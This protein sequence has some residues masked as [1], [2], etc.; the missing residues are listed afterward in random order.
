MW[1]HRS[2][3]PE[4]YHAQNQGIQQ[5]RKDKIRHNE[6]DSHLHFLFLFVRE[7]TCLRYADFMVVFCTITVQGEKCFKPQGRG[8]SPT[9]NGSCRLS[10]LRTQ[11]PHS[12]I[13]L[14][15][16]LPFMGRKPLVYKK[17]KQNMAMAEYGKSWHLM[18]NLR[19]WKFRFSIQ[20]SLI[21]WTS[22]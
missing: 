11:M 18:M 5:S 10:V 14:S 3:V 4:A 2:H 8:G 20:K 21:M 15:W 7:H 17:E 22:V 1:L 13:G 16:H 6:T 19:T 12:A 9:H